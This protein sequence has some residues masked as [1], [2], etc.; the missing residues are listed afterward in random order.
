MAE[1][2]I[3]SA[4]MEHI[5]GMLGVLQCVRQNKKQARREMLALLVCSQLLRP[6]RW[7]WTS[8]A[9]WCTRTMTRAPCRAARTS[10]ARHG[11]RV[12]VRDDA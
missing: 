3:F 1:A 10:V 6:P 8:T 9:C 12:S 4:S 7:W 5:K 11:V 2:H